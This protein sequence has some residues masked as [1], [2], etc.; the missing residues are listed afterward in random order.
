MTQFTANMWCERCQRI[1]P[2]RVYFLQLHGNT[3]DDMCVHIGHLCL[4]DIGLRKSCHKYREDM[5]WVRDYNGLVRI[6][7]EDYP[8]DF[9]TEG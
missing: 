9:N 4:T 2:H 7:K 3:K 1:V 8:S 5:L 6:A